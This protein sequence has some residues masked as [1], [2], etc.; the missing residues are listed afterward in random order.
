V[1]KLRHDAKTLHYEG[2]E[3]H[4]DENRQRTFGAYAA[5]A[6]SMRLVRDQ[7]KWTRRSPFVSLLL[8]VV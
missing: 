7:P 5:T 1:R 3:D 2:H 6:W 4:E 8:F